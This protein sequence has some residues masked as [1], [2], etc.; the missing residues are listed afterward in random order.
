MGGALCLL[1]PHLNPSFSSY[2]AAAIAT[3]FAEAT[4]GQEVL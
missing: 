2:G 1:Q 3:G 4:L